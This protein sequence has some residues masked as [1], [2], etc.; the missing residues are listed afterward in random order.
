MVKQFQRVERGGRDSVYEH[1]KNGGSVV[2]YKDWRL[3]LLGAISVEQHL[4]GAES[5]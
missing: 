5:V 3:G 2:W 4:A 1:R